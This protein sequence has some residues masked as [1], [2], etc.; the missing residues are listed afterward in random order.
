MAALLI[1]SFCFSFAYA[2]E[3]YLINN[4]VESFE[5]DGWGGGGTNCGSQV[6]A[7]I[8]DNPVHEGAG[9]LELTYDF[10]GKNEDIT[11]C[12]YGKYVL[13]PGKKITTLSLWVYGDGS[14]LLFYVRLND[15]TG[16][17]I[18]YSGGKLDWRGWRKVSIDIS[19][20]VGHWGGDNNGVLS[21][22]IS[23][24]TFII[25]VKEKAYVGRGQ[26]YIDELVA[27]S[28]ILESDS[29]RLE[30][31]SDKVGNIFTEEDAIGFRLKLVN[32]SPKNRELDLF[33]QV[34]S[35]TDRTLGS[36]N[37]QV[38]VDAAATKTQVLSL[39]I[40]VNG[41]YN[42]RLYLISKDRVIRLEQNVPFSRIVTP[43]AA[44]E[45]NPVFGVCTHN[46]LGGGVNTDK[47]NSVASLAGIY[48]LRDEILWKTAEKTK[49]QFE[50]PPKM[51]Y[52]VNDAVSRGLKLLLILC[53]GNPLYDQG[54]P[55][56]TEEGIAAFVR[57]A[58]FMAEHFKGR[59]DHFEVWNEY[60]LDRSKRPP[61]DYAKLIKAAYPAIK[62]AN[63]AA[64]VV[65][66]CTAGASLD[67]I[68]RVLAA[69]AYDY[70]DAISIH[71]YC[72]PLSPD[73]GGTVKSIEMTRELMLRYGEEKPIWITEIGWPTHK[74]E[75]GVSELVSGAYAVRLYTLG[76]AAGA[77]KI[78]W[79][80][81]Q[82]D[83]TDLTNNENNFGLIKTRQGVP[84]PWAAKDNFI[85][86]STLT[87]KLADVQF[88]KAHDFDNLKIY[89][90]RKTKD[91]RDL[92]VLWTL[93]GSQTIGLKS[94][95][96]LA[97]DLFG[98]S[99]NLSATAGVITLTVSP[100]P[101]YLEGNFDEL[102]LTSP[103]FDLGS[104]TLSLLAGETGKIKVTLPKDCALSG[105]F[106]ADLPSNW[107]LLG[108]TAFS[109]E[110][111][112]VELEVSSP[113]QTV[114]DNYKLHLY[115]VSGQQVLAKLSV[116]IQLVDP[117]GLT[118]SP[119]LVDRSEWKK[120]SL[121]LL[122]TN[123]S[124]TQTLDGTI[125]L[126]EPLSWAGKLKP[127][128]FA[129]LQPGQT[130][131]IVVPIPQEIECSAALTFAVSLTQG[132]N[133]LFS[134]TTSFLAAVKTERQIKL[135]GDLSEWQDAMPFALNQAWQVKEIKDW[136]G[137]DDLSGKGYLK[138]DRD[139][140]YLSLDVTDNVH[141]QDD[142]GSATWRGDGIQFSIDPGFSERPG[143]YGYHELGVALHESKVTNW[144]WSAAYGMDV[145]ELKDLQCAIA[146]RDTHTCYEMAIP[147]SDLIDDPTKIGPGSVIGFSLLIND[148]DGAGRRG[149]I[150]YNSGIGLVKDPSAFGDLL[151]VE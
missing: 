31:E 70:M 83:G 52:A 51:E 69:G 42:L 59:V 103:G 65:G 73:W 143:K 28:E 106:L 49:G 64:F 148:N 48:M 129:G 37:M 151:L 21:A 92:L 56:Y 121:A 134:T 138:W 132:Y 8:V 85:A 50:I 118:V 96:T 71:P 20:P 26:I 119:E 88:V 111:R 39:A 5:T 102:Q 82:D 108:E 122:L 27:E 61:E 141:R 72:Y 124:S 53:Y 84:V 104:Q 101:I 97:T 7:K 99:F 62:A 43:V 11:Y 105:N 55:P 125:T 126:R 86:Y 33:Y 145:G 46:I 58:A 60:N 98:N 34:N 77:D 91:D 25:D 19:K 147:W 22:P 15:G 95:G 54:G 128:A 66:C 12:D 63:P 150:E 140:L 127:I 47:N 23:L 2:E 100:E 79:Y 117:I 18:Q 116:D 4:I 133:E 142:L 41:N 81:L 89:Q 3:A 32:L 40:P 107:R 10:V 109:A 78:F 44:G 144:R 135:D 75:R 6:A 67:W 74:D 9:S 38:K 16:E 13:I 137:T 131:K 76:M 1:G 139:Y 94:E 45:K 115:P 30:V 123:N 24:F 136:G 113:G 35:T 14:G 112:T 87:K 130:R 29:L 90:F 68:D 93:H 149:W 110:N 57:Y 36:G 17:T 114:L 146:R 80:D 120:W